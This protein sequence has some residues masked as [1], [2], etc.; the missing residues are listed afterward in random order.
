MVK[1]IILIFFLSLSSACSLHHIPGWTY[2]L[3]VA[4]SLVMESHHHVL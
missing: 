3:V 4:I 2:G 1:G